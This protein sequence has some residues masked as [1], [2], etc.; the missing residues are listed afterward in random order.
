MVTDDHRVEAA[1]KAF[2]RYYPEGLQ[3]YVDWRRLIRIALEAADSVR[4]PCG[5]TKE[6]EVRYCQLCQRASDHDHPKGRQ[7]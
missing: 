6:F 1:L 7:Y 3:P 5:H 2:N 4:M